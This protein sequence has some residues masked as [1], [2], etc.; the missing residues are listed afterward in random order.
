MARLPFHKKMCYLEEKLDIRI[1]TWSVNLR[2][3][4]IDE[5]FARRNLLLHCGGVVD[6]LYLNRVSYSPFREGNIVSVDEHYFLR[7]TY[8]FRSLAGYLYRLLKAKVEG[9]YATA[10]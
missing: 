5:V 4:E 8:G 9:T 10:D 2:L 7:A 3:C 6:K 1:D